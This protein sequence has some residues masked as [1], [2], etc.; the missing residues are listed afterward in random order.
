MGGFLASS[1]QLA[2]HCDQLAVDC[3]CRQGP[4]CTGL[5]Y[6][7]SYLSFI[8]QFRLFRQAAVLVA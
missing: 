7:H 4:S 6:I 2:C 3:W 1:I 5:L 8:E